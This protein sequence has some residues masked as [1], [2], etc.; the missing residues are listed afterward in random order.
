MHICLLHQSLAFVASVCGVIHLL[1]MLPAAVSHSC[2]CAALNH[3]LCCTAGGKKAPAEESS[4]RSKRP[5]NSDSTPPTAADLKQVLSLVLGEDAE[6][7][8]P[9]MHWASSAPDR[10]APPLQ[11]D[12]SM[13]EVSTIARLT[14]DQYPVMRYLYQQGTFTSDGWL[15]ST[16]KHPDLVLVSGKPFF[17]MVAGPIN[18]QLA[19]VYLHSLEVYQSYAE[20][21]LYLPDVSWH[22]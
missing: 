13:V 8:S 17:A 14:A 22:T 18:T 21:I 6:Q 19:S 4:R 1:A 11:I 12:E 9:L 10:Q 15:Q 16:E 3:V 20:L 7:P 2:L 5:R